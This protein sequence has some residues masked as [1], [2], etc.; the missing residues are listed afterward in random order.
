M[1]FVDADCKLQTD[2]LTTLASAIRDSPQHNCFQL[3][4]TG[5]RAGLVGRAEELRLNTLQNHLLQPNGCI[6]YLNTSGFAIRR[7]SVEVERGLFDPAAL[8]AE[9]T[10][11]LADLMQI[12][13]LPLFVTNAIVQHGIPS[14]LIKC[15]LKDMR[16][17]YLK[18]STFDLIASKGVRI[19]ASHRE[20]L[21]M[22]SSMWKTSQRQSIGRLAWFVVLTRQVLARI[23][24]VVCSC[25]RLRPSSHTPASSS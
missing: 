19:R 12:G 11:L 16:S 22:M 14:S 17:A 7:K 25:F 23:V 6:R 13:E 20:R 3:H 8:R 5:D 9:D 18:G 24:S 21:G 1:L 4:L 10:L 2:C 15:L